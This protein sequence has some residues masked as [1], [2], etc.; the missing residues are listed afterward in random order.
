[1]ASIYS[2]GTGDYARGPARAGAALYRSTGARQRVM[3][4]AGMAVNT[5]GAVGN[6]ILMLTHPCSDPDNSEGDCKEEDRSPIG[7]LLIDEEGETM[8]IALPPKANQVGRFLANTGEVAIFKEPTAWSATTSL[9]T[10]GQPSM[11]R[12]IGTARPPLPAPT[13]A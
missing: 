9:P 2:V 5:W 6:E 4:P 3:L 11:G 7:A 10:R 1:M 13:L 8:E 12:A